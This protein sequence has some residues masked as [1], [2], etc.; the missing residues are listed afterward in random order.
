MSRQRAMKKQSRKR[1]R[2][3]WMAAGTLAA[4][5]AVRPSARAL[6]AETVNSAATGAAAPATLPVRRFEIASG[7]LGAVLE[8]YRAASGVKVRV[9]DAGLL[10]IPSPGV[11]GVMSVEVALK[12]L[13]VGTS[14]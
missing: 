13:L 2:S 8:A 5:A 9:P 12:Q 4:Y 14:V 7:P 3:V 10:Q 1:T 11:T 6:A